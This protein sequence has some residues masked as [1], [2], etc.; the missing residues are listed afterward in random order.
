MIGAEVAVFMNT[1]RRA[2]LNITTA[3][4]V[5]MAS[6]TEPPVARTNAVLACPDPVALDYHA[7]KYL[8]YPNSK[9]AVHDPDDSESPLHQYLVKCAEYGGGEFDERKV[10]VKSYDFKTGKLQENDEL[11]LI[12]EKEWGW[13]AKM[14][15]KY[16]VLRNG[17]IR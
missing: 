17:L 12:G 11:V 2:H 16:V 15:L 9:I 10:E 6:R 13:N 3:K 8:L 7:T 14:W 1:I 5:G 4:W